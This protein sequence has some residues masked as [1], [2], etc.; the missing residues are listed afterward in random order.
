[1]PAFRYVSR[2]VG[3]VTVES[4]SMDAGGT[5]D[6]GDEGTRDAGDQGRYAARLTVEEVMKPLPA[7]LALHH[8]VAAAR[9][10]MWAFD[11]SYMVVVAPATGKLLGVVLRRTLER[12]CESR[13]HD[14]EECPLVRHLKTDI[15]FCLVGERVDEVFGARPTSIPPVRSGRP[16]PEM[17]RRNAIPVIV[18][19]E[20]KIPVG[21]LLR[22]RSRPIDG[23][24]N[25]E[26]RG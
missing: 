15:D 22:P 19:D 25:S 11:S 5:R 13:G 23:D 21:L 10:L 24:T 9:E 7:R 17:R 18:V 20:H 3:L 1:M 6:S 4:R 2:G 16:P 26:E 14:P 12:G 8:S